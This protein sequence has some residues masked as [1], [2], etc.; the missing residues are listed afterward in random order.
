MWLVNSMK[1]IY[2]YDTHIMSY[3]E[4]TVKEYLAS[5]QMSKQEIDNN[6]NVLNDFEDLKCYCCEYGYEVKELYLNF[7]IDLKAFMSK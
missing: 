3:D 5:M 7:G 1:Q 2:Y 4:E 6:V